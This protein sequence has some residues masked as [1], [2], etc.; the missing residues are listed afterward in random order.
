MKTNLDKYFKTDSKL[1]TEGVWFDLDDNVG[2]LVRRFGGNNSPS[3]KAAMQKHYKPYARQIEAGTLDQ[4]K[5][6]EIGVKVF[7]NACMLDWKG[8]EID[9]KEVPF[10]KEAAVDLLIKLPDLSKALIDYA[11][12]LD[13]YKVDLGNG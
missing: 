12:S 3:V 7:V 6:L 13:S 2:F 4:K 10:S 11:Q 8:V 9:G 5:D 1:E